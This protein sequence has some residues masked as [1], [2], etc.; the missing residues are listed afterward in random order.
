MKIYYILILLLSGCFG[1]S[2]ANVGGVKIT[3][4]DLITAPSKIEKLNKKENDG[5]K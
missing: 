5:H 3:A 2:I 4:G 1:P